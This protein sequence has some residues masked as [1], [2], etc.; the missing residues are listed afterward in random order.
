MINIFYSLTNNSLD[1]MLIERNSAERGHIPIVTNMAGKYL[2]YVYASQAYMK[3]HAKAVRHEASQAGTSTHVHNMGA[4]SKIKEEDEGGEEDKDE[5]DEELNEAVL[6]APEEETFD[7]YPI[8]DSDQQDSRTDGR[9]HLFHMPPET[10]VQFRSRRLTAVEEEEDFLGP[11][12]QPYRAQR[13]PLASIHADPAPKHDNVP[14]LP[15]RS[16]VLLPSL[17]IIP[18]HKKPTSRSDIGFPSNEMA[19]QLKLAKLEQARHRPVRPLGTH[20]DLA[21]VQPARPSA[22]PARPANMDA[23][24]GAL[25]R[26]P[27]TQSLTPTPIPMGR[28]QPAGSSPAPARG[29]PVASRAPLRGQLPHMHRH[30]GSLLARRPFLLVDNLLASFSI[31]TLILREMFS[32]LCQ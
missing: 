5:D 13:L 22:A 7:G 15:S 2:V 3:R 24:Y 19:R 8:I 18:D 14:A 16:S 4:D 27:S 28:M 25:G 9:Q 12:P 32:H 11:V 6:T 17:P 20:A 23:F 31:S 1:E 21:P 26:P 30:L 10:P 29:R